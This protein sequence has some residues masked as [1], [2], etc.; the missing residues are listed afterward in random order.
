[1]TIVDVL[2]IVIKKRI[3]LNCPVHHRV[4]RKYYQKGIFVINSE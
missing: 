3:D 1:M 4:F 2:I